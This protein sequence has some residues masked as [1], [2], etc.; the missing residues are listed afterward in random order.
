MSFLSTASRIG[1]G[2]EP[3][4]QY[5]GTKGAMPEPNTLSFPYAVASVA[6]DSAQT[7]ATTPA[8]PVA[9]A[10]AKVTALRRELAALDD[11]MRR[12]KSTHRVCETQLWGWPD[13]LA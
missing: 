11:T 4:T 2:A 7:L 12:F 5:F 8:D 9:E 1:A 13:C 10:L 6:S 3:T